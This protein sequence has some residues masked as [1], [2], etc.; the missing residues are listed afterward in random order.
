MGV[1]RE[2]AAAAG[3]RKA[4]VAAR[5]CGAAIAKVFETGSSG[6]AAELVVVSKAVEFVKSLW[7]MEEFCGVKFVGNCYEQQGR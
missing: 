5:V 2:E 6:A 7:A 3:A 4:M 1:R